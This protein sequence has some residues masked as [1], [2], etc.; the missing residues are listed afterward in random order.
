MAFVYILRCCDD[1]LYVGVTNDLDLRVQEHNDGL[2]GSYTFKRR[3]VEMVYS[4]SCD[5]TLSA[6]RRE[7]QLKGWTRA[8][9][10]ALIARNVKELKRLS[11]CRTT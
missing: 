10:E 3:P 2:G 5:S 8:K 9:K 6:R 11:R 7:R 1:S 4:E